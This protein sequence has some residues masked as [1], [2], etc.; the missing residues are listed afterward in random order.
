[1]ITPFRAAHFEELRSR[2]PESQASQDI[3]PE[4][5][6]AMERRGSQTF[7]GKDGRVLMVFG[8]VEIWKGR[9]E[10]WAVLEQNCRDEFLAMHRAA[11][12]WLDGLPHERLEMTVEAG[13]ADGHRWARLLGFELEAVRMK[14]YRAGRDY[15]LYARVKCHT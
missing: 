5:A 10:V 3:S 14:Q 12:K 4:I 15:S 1:M 11:L 6:R 8:A 13:F 9:A 2:Q 7:L